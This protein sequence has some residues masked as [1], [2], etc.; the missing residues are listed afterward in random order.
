VNI[1]IVGASESDAA[2]LWE[3]LRSRPA[4]ADVCALS[5]ASSASLLRKPQSW[6][7]L[8]AVNL[9]LLLGLQA[10]SAPES[11]HVD[12]A[13]RTAL[14]QSAVAYAVVHGSDG[15][16]LDNALQAIHYALGAPRAKPTTSPWKWPCEKC[17]DP[18]CEH[19]L[20]S[21][22]LKKG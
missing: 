15:A 16:R 8:D 3:Q 10:D 9:V 4:I 22:V 20:F 2:G 12:Q 11:H 6:N 7:S 18:H 14:N 17:S 1:A 21:D 19:R 5:L 13:L